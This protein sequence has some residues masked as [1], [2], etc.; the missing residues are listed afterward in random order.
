MQKQAQQWAFAQI[1]TKREVAASLQQP[2][3]D[4]AIGVEY[5][6]CGTTVT[7]DE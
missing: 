3:M 7:K 1:W 5:V 4:W 6:T 2:Q